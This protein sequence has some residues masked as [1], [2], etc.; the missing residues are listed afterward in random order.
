VQNINVI[1]FDLDDTLYDHTEASRRALRDTAAL[2]SALREVAHDELERIN[3][4]WLEH[5]HLEVQRGTL[6]LADARVAR[7]RKVLEH[8]NANSVD[9]ETL[10]VAH[11]E[12]Y[13]RNECLVSAAAETLSALRERGFRLAIVSNSTYNEQLGKLQRLRIARFFEHV[14]V[15]ADHGF[16]K[17]DA[18]LFEVAIKRLGVL[19]ADVVH[20]GDSWAADV[21][22]ARNAGVAP[23]WFNRFGQSSPDSTVSQFSALS[24]L[25]RLLENLANSR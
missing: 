25:P 9:A 8:F 7:W 4:E 5:F 23:L 2:D 15:S 10:A 1:F 24:E 17:P 14:V 3:S 18:R 6:A 20:V 11:R 22:G 13:L 21:Q 16:A 19:A 12:N